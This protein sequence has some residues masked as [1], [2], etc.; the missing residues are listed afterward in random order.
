MFTDYQ[1]NNDM[2]SVKLLMFIEALTH[3]FTGLDAERG[4]SPA[5]HV[6]ASLSMSISK[7][8]TPF[9]FHLE[10]KEVY[11]Q[12]NFIWTQKFSTTH[13]QIYNKVRAA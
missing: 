2:A 4:L 10:L 5:P 11:P 6:C 9:V 3:N 12:C 8:H 7:L 13:S 1:D